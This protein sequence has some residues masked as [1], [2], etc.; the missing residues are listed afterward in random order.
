MKKLLFLFV[1]IATMTFS[2]CSDDDDASFKYDM[3]TIY[4]R[5]SGIAVK[6]EGTWIDITTPPGNILAFSA[7]FKSD[8]T[9][10]G[11]GYFGT[12][13]GTYKAKGDTLITYI[14][15]K[16]YA[17]Y[18]IQSISGNIAEMTMS[19]NKESIEIRCRKQK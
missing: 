14:E 2:G 5:W 19:M 9:Y 7:T 16:E 13:S 15:G 3:E 10:S 12:G 17:R 1:A 4:G 8:G 11:D 6:S 18:K